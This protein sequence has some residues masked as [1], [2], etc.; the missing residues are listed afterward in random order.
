VG[1]DLAFAATFNGEHD[2]YYLRIGDHDCNQNGIGDALDISSGA[3]N[4]VNANGIPDE[5]ETSGGTPF[6][7]GDGSGTACPCGNSG[8]SGNGCANSLFAGGAKLSSIGNQSVSAD[9]LVLQGAGMPN[10]SALYFQGT[11]PQ[12]GGLGSVFGDGLRCAGG[13]VVRLATKTNASGAS[14]YPGTGDPSVSVRGMVVAPGVRAYQVWYRNAA[15]FCT[16]DTF[17]LTNGLSVTWGP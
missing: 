10:S 15:V 17:N 9:S 2:V 11:A 12:N 14:Q 1:A 6:C 5:C 8:M 4:D 13:T 3:S 7:S 16:P